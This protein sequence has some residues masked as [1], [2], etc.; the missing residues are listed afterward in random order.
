MS[1]SLSQPRLQTLP[2]FVVVIVNVPRRSAHIPVAGSCRVI[3]AGAVI[4]VLI[5]VA[6]GIERRTTA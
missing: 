3:M 5:V 2:Q 4:I 6:V 1:S